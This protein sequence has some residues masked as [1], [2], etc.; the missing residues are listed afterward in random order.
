M[1]IEGND[2]SYEAYETPAYPSM[3]YHHIETHW[4]LAP[5]PTRICEAT[6]VFLYGIHCE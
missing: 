3:L 5:T 4:M 1:V 2:P 6:D